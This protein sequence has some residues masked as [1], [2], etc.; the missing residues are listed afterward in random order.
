MPYASRST[1]GEN[2]ASRNRSATP[3]HTRG[4]GDLFHARVGG[5]LRC[6][7]RCCASPAVWQRGKARGLRRR[8]P[9]E[10]SGR[11]GVGVADVVVQR[12]RRR[13]DAREVRVHLLREELAAHCL[14]G[15][16]VADGV[17][18]SCGDV[19]Q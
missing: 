13:E 18:A 15:R 14:S 4:T 1:V 8:L 7:L 12:A 10:L 2:P 9:E 16:V 3:L 17:E 11:A 19:R 6:A 5:W